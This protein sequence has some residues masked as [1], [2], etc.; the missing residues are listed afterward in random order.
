M[1]QVIDRNE[2]WNV[3]Q[4]W[5]TIFLVTRHLF[6]M[7]DLKCYRWHVI[8]IIEWRFLVRFFSCVAV[9]HLVFETLNTPYSCFHVHHCV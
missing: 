9:L 3:A 4:T 8:S 2:R 6:R 1:H 7:D 5:M